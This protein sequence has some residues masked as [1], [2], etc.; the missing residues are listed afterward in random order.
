MNPSVYDD[1]SIALDLRPPP[2]YVPAWLREIQAFRGREL[3]AE[4]RRPAFKIG[5][6]R[7]LDA[8]DRDVHAYHLTTRDAETGELLGCFRMMPLAGSP[9]SQVDAVLGPEMAERAL[10]EIGTQ[11]QRMME[12]ARW[13]VR[14][15]QQGRGVGYLLMAS[16][17]AL[18]QLLGHDGFW[19]V[20]GI[21]DGQTARCLRA[22]YR[23]IPGTTVLSSELFADELCPLYAIAARPSSRLAP[24]VE[25]LLR[26]A[27]PLVAALGGRAPRA[28]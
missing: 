15:D 22:G 27:S 9:P 25:G 14:R 23:P 12:S 10:A 1:R 28:A 7:Y 2:G 19:A 11:R 8:E 4:G 24:L 6:D 3:Y 17:F 18:S 5:E 13:I 26:D 20:A 21:R 16:G